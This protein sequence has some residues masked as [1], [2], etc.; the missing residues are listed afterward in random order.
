MGDAADIRRNADNQNRY[1]EVNERVM[2]VKAEFDLLA[3]GGR[4]I[5]EVLCECSDASCADRVEIT[6]VAYER[7]RSDRETFV[8]TCGHDRG[9]SRS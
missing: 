9:W 5:V 7:V 6:R 2:A 4:R 8:L 1:R 3:E